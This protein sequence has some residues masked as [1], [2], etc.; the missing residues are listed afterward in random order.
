MALERRGSTIGWLLLIAI[1]A[2]GAVALLSGPPHSEG[3]LIHVVIRGETL[4]TIGGFE[5][6]N[7]MVGAVMASL[8]LLAAAW[9][10]SRRSALIP[11]RMQSLLELPIELFAGIVATSTSRWRGYVALVIGLFLMILISN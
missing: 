7:S 3:G 4:L 1:A 8:I 5:V 2:A 10:I 6:T 11:H 9:Y